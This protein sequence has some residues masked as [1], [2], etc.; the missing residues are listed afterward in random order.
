M[1]NQKELGL[2][3]NQVKKALNKYE[4]LKVQSLMLDMDMDV[5]TF[6][7]IPKRRL[8]KSW[9]DRFKYLNNDRTPEDYQ[10]W[11]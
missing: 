10:G 7:L 2:N 4:D 8:T 5:E 6:Q 9:R 3:K 11:E 1:F